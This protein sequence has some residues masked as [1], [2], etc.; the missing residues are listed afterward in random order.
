MDAGLN[1]HRFLDGDV[2]DGCLRVTSFTVTGDVLR[3]PRVANAVEAFGRSLQE[4]FACRLDGAGG[5]IPFQLAWN[6]DL[7][8]FGFRVDVAQAGV[9]VEAA[10]DQGLAQALQYLRREMADRMGPWLEVG[11]IERFPGLTTA[12][13]EGIFVPA[14]QQADNPGDFSDA[15]LELMAHFGATGMK[16]VLDLSK[17]WKSVSL[18]ELDAR[19]VEVKFGLLE[20]H[21]CRLGR[22]GLDL[23]LIL[24]MP[25]FPAEHRVFQNHPE[26]C[27]AEEEIFMEELSGRND[28][29]LCST[30]PRVRAAYG[31]VIGNLMAGVPS[32]AGVILL[33]GGEGFRHCFT[34]PSHVDSR[35]TNCP[36]CAEIGPHLCVAELANTVAA[37]VKHAS[38]SPRLLVWPYSA[39]VW[40]R[41]DPGESRWIAHLDAGIEVLSNFD[42][43]DLDPHGD[44]QVMLFD[45]NIRIRGPSR[46]FQA[47]A[48]ACERT[49]RPILAKTETTT[50]P[51]TPFVPFLPLPFLW[52]ERFRAIRESGAAGFV[53]QWRFYGMNGSLPEELQYHSIWN[54]E[55]T[56]EEL[57]HTA[58]RRDYGVSELAADQVVEG[59]RM[60]GEAWSH[61]PYSAMTCGERDAYFRG[62][63][64]LGPAHPLIFN[65]LDSYGL[66]PKFFRRR[67]DLA[68]ALSAEEIALLPGAPRYSSDLLFCL[69]YGAE[70]YAVRLAECRKQWDAALAR[71]E[72]V[73]EPGPTGRARLD[74]NVVRMLG[75]HLNS[76]GNVLAFMTERDALGREAHDI[77]SFERSCAAILGIVDREV[78][79]AKVALALV[80]DD[81]RLG[82]GHTYGEV[83]DAEMIEDKIRQCEFLIN[84]ELPR[85]RS[86]IRFHVWYRFP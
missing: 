53:G 66:G 27:G 69:P 73:L 61:F 13:T 9:H 8:R 57:L 85:I 40:S 2:P 11:V 63:W 31:E 33:V 75:C 48:V 41:D 77:E 72:G 10:T 83:Y 51:D 67:G 81:A 1:R 19:E 54:P 38:G 6:P 35:G 39:F 24:N 58:A 26:V 74:L 30:E 71:L 65:P 4:M 59:W 7:P 79:N 20:A 34:R 84:S 62:P 56:A 47:Q 36:R 52:F 60:L 37:A 17:L 76:L 70:A 22:F 68:E 49:A 55:R 12:L 23:F 29:V 44:G 28:R 3:V 14:D 43:G 80:R 82:F 50:T 64:Y 78:A 86:V 32:A 16:V 18:P 25:S 42:C 5:G 15:E 21:A 45:Y 46:R